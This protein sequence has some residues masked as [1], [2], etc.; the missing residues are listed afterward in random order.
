MAIEE[1]L[2][3]EQKN[4]KYRMR[5]CISKFISRDNY[6]IIESNIS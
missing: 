5:N 3:E 6:A 1:N 2:G 4:T